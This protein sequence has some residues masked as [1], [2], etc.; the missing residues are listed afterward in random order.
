M[1]SL[2]TQQ[3]RHFFLSLSLTFAVTAMVCVHRDIQNK[4]EFE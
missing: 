3:K 4:D 1:N 2:P